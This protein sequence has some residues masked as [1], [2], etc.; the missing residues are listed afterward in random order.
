MHVTVCRHGKRE[1]GQTHMGES[2]VLKSN[3]MVAMADV[4]YHLVQESLTSLYHAV[5][6]LFVSMSMCLRSNVEHMISGCNQ[7]ERLIQDGHDLFWG[8]GRKS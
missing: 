7:L 2:L 5:F 1:F 6:I 3:N 8:I 4:D